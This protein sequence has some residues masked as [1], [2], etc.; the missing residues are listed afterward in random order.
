LPAGDVTPESGGV[1]V[2]GE[3]P[4]ARV[5]VICGSLR[6]VLKRADLRT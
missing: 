6:Q 2:D 3:F 4:C 1:G 5:L